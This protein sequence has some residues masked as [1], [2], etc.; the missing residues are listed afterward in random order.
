MRPQFAIGNPVSSSLPHPGRHGLPQSL[1]TMLCMLDNW[2]SIPAGNCVGTLDRFFDLSPSILLPSDWDIMGGNCNKKLHQIAWIDI[3][4]K[5]REM[6]L[7]LGVI[8]A[9]QRT[10]KSTA[11][12]ARHC[13]LWRK[14]TSEGHRHRSWIKSRQE[15]HSSSLSSSLCSPACICLTTPSNCSSSHPT[16]CLVIV[17]FLIRPPRRVNASSLNKIVSN[18]T[19]MRASFYPPSTR[20]RPNAEVI[21]PN[22]TVHI[23]NIVMV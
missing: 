15:Y 17:A 20:L 5:L 22:L 18:A 19:K 13:I 11:Q 12:W 1:S 7:V 9:F 6:S 14:S 16:D 23:V 21:Q 4:C 2:S 8:T 3:L 10:K